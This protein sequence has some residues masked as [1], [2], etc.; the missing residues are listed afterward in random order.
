[1]FQLEEAAYVKAP[2]QEGALCFKDWK[3][4]QYIGLRRVVLRD[5]AE[6]G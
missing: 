3:E 2:F 5:K 6:A 4:G 1:M